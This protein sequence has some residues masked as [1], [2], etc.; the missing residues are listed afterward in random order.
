MMKPLFMLPGEPFDFCREHF[1]FKV[2]MGVGVPNVPGRRVN[3][4]PEYFVLKQGKSLLN[5]SYI[6]AYKKSVMH[7]CIHETTAYFTSTS[8]ANRLPAGYFLSGSKSS[9]SLGASKGP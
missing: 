1:H 7:N 8:A 4:G 6:L 2:S 9:K 5:L 3:D